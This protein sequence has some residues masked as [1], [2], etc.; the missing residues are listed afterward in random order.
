[1]CVSGNGPRAR[2]YPR[3]VMLSASMIAKGR[4]MGLHTVPPCRDFSATNSVYRRVG[5]SLPGIA[6]KHSRGA[7]MARAHCVDGCRHPVRMTLTRYGGDR[8]LE[9]RGEIIA[10]QCTR[11]T[12]KIR[13]GGVAF[14]WQHARTPCGSAR[15]HRRRHPR[16]NRQGST[17]RPGSMRWTCP[18]TLSP[19]P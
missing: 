8:N 10:G 13:Q 2:R 18:S 17:T 1:M 5:R 4:R 3:D 9:P 6:R 15:N 12:H 14:A 19:I 7:P 16:S 11:C